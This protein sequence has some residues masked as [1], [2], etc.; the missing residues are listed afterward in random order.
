MQCK[1]QLRTSKACMLKK[2]ITVVGTH[3]VK[4][5]F[6][7]YLNI[8]TNIYATVQPE[9]IARRLLKGNMKKCGAE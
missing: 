7:K 9:T 4:M 6:F 2:V 8:I 1:V 3:E 5:H